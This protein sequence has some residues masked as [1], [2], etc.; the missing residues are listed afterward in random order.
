MSRSRSK[1]SLEIDVLTVATERVLCVQVQHR[2]VRRVDELKLY[3]ETGAHGGR[4]VVLNFGGL[5]DSHESF[6]LSTLL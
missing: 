6:K 5:I 4:Y 2:G 3:T 1:S